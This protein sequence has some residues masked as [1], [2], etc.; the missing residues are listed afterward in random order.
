MI[1]A[2][3]LARGTDDT[4]PDP[5]D[6]FI[7]KVTVYRPR[8]VTL[9]GG[10]RDTC[11]YRSVCQCLTRGRSL[12]PWWNVGRWSNVGIEPPGPFHSFPIARD[13]RVG[14]VLEQTGVYCAVATAI[15]GKQPKFG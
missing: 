12:E 14:S 6:L 1:E 7:G 4:R 10:G 3:V 9:I 15:A 8:A 2:T 11:D 5:V 13:T